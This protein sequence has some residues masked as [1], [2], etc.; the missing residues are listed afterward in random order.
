MKW[1]RHRRRQRRC[2]H[3]RPEHPAIAIGGTFQLSNISAETV[4][5]AVSQHRIRSPSGRLTGAI[6][7]DAVA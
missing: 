5:T 3:Y 1:R 4:I 2:Q 6:G 7:A